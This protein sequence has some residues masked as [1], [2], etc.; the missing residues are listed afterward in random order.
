MIER[1]TRSA[2]FHLKEKNKSVEWFTVHT[3]LFIINGET[4][5]PDFS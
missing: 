4:N 5:T 2:I 3:Y 1:K